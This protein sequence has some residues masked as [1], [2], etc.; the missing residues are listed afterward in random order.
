MAESLREIDR[1]GHVISHFSI[2]VYN[3]ECPKCLTIFPY[4]DLKNEGLNDK[5]LKCPKCKHSFQTYWV[6]EKCQ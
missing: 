5:T 3:V 1:Y 4:K 6:Y 2:T